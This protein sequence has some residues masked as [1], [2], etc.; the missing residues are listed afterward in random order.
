MDVQAKIVK[1]SDSV[2]RYLVDDVCEQRILL[3]GKKCLPAARCRHSRWNVVRV[4]RERLCVSRKSVSSSSSI[5]SS[6]SSFVP[7]EFE[8]VLL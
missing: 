6:D 2:L 5:H 7:F 1:A 3:A 4:Y 8:S